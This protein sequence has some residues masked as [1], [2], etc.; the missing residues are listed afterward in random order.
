M[1]S[2][3][4]LILLL[5]Q[6]FLLMNVGCIT[7][8]RQDNNIVVKYD[9]NHSVTIDELN[10]YIKDWLYYKKFQ[11]RSDAY[12]HALNDMVINQLKRIDF[13]EKG[14]DKDEKLIQSMN[15]IINEELVAEYFET[16]Y[17]GKYTTE[18]NAIKIYGMMNKEVVYQLIEIS[19]PKDA[20]PKQLDS[21]KGKA[22]EIQSEI[23]HGKDFSLL[24]KE[25]S[26]NK[27]SLINNGFMPPLS[28]KQS[29]LN[30]FNRIVYHL[31]K[32]DV[33]VLN[34]TNAFQ[35]VKIS[36][37]HY[38]DLKPYDSMKSNIIS[39]LKSIYGDTSLSEYEKDKEALIDSKSMKWN[40]GALKEI[41]RLSNI[42]NF[43]QG[44]YQKTFKDAIENR[45]NK[46]VLTYNGGTV[47][48]KE[49][50][51]LLDNVLI[52]RDFNGIKEEDIK[53]YIEEAIRTDLI[54]KKAESLDLQKNIFH[55]YTSNPALKV[56]I[57]H[58]YN[59]A[60]I[61]AKL[62]EVTDETLHRFYRENEN[63]LYYQL[64]KRNLF[65]MIFPTKEDAEKAAIKIEHGTPFEKVTGQ[66][67]VETDIKERLGEI[68]SFGKNE[69]P[70]FGKIGFELKESEV[71]GPVEFK[72][73]NNLLKYAIIKCYHIRPE[74]QLTYN[75]VKDTIT[76][77]FKNYYREKMEKE[78]DQKLINQYK[79]VIYKKVL[80][81]VISQN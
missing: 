73:K 32:N 45:N 79:P 25:Y 33:R 62:P 46:I 57:V 31:S 12:N 67:V 60:E 1:S 75:D 19:K 71:T 22:L 39:D 36:D 74:K 49:L 9:S 11:D 28:W 20:S 10:K 27:T 13:F 47:D 30:P 5:V 7:S 8:K 54:V 37:V 78:I 51:R 61:E 26:Q 14:L 40:D 65:V 53:K 35:I 64:E 56:Q 3:R 80:A 81:K 58:L 24:V 42:P 55:A 16:Q 66:Y 15:R 59:Q 76:E 23:D 17:L 68:K 41:V 29:F 38:T 4:Y 69:K 52:I 48:Y 43:Y 44:E 70:T 21:L 2:Y 63:I 6:L 18:E 72:D 34:S 50:L 77:D